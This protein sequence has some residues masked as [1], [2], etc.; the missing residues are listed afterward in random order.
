MP[1]LPSGLRDKWQRLQNGTML[2]T[3]AQ[4]GRVAEVDPQGRMVWE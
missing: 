3:E 4:A 1:R 2:F